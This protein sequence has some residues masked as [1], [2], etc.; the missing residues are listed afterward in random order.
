MDGTLADAVAAA[1]GD[2]EGA[3]ADAAAEDAAG[4]NLDFYMA[5]GYGWGWS[6]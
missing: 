2:V 5:K 4:A 1:T 3:A 6:R